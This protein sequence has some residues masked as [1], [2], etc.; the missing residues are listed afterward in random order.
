MVVNGE[1]TAI[2][3]LDLERFRRVMRAIASALYCKEH[4]Q[5]CV[6]QWEVLSPTLLGAN[7]IAGIPDDWQRFRDLMRR[8]P[9]QPKAAPEASV[10]RYGVHSFEDARHF[11]YALEFYGGF[12]IYVWNSK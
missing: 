5:S 4:D 10:F 9:F 7:D 6:G 11:A 1:P 3:Q 12:H 2:F 8:I